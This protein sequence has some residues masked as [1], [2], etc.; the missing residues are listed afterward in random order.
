M[1]K[2]ITLINSNK[3]DKAYSILN[4]KMY[5]VIFDSNTFIH[6]CA[7]RGRI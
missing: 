1:D 2:I 3:W 6:I 4:K 7:F 5:S